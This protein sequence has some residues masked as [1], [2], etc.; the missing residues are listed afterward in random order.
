MPTDPSTRT[1]GPKLLRERPF[2]G[3]AVHFLAILPSGMG[4]LLAG[5]LTTIS[6]HESPETTPDT[7]SSGL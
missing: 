7:P 4:L 6:E 1:P 3:T 2:G 5:G